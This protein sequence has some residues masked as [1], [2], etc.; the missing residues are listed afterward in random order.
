MGQVEKWDAF[1]LNPA[2]Q[3]HDFIEQFSF[4]KKISVYTHEP[5]NPAR[6]SREQSVYCNT[7]QEPHNLVVT[8]VLLLWTNHAWTGNIL[9]NF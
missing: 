6:R 2:N 3:K 1:L 4:G 5:G 9:R 7:H 8:T